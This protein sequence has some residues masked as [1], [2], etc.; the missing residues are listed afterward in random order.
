MG[1]VAML[2]KIDFSHW[3]RMGRSPAALVVLPCALLLSACGG[4]AKGGGDAASTASTTTV[5]TGV[6]ATGAP[7]MGAT[8]RVV[9]VQGISVPLLAADGVATVSSVNTLAGGTYQFKISSSALKFPLMIQAAGFDANGAPMVLHSVVQSPTTGASTSSLV[10]NI[11][12]ATDAVV[13]QVLG[14]D[15]VTVF[16]NAPSRAGDIALLGDAD[17][18]A[19]ASD[20]VKAIIAANLTDAKVANAKTLDLFKDAAFKANKTGLDAALDGVRILMST[21]ATGANQL[22]WSNKFT[23]PTASAPEATL[24]L[25]TAR[26]ELAKKTSGSIAKAISSTTKVTTSPNKLPLL[27]LAAMDT[28][29]DDLNQQIARGT[30]A[31]FTSL[32]AAYTVHNGHTKAELLAKLSG[33][34]KQ[35]YQFG[36]FQ[37]VGCAPVVA[38][39]AAIK[40][41]ECARVLVAAVVTDFQGTPKEIFRDAVKVTAATK[42]TPATWSLIGNGQPTEIGVFPVALARF[43]LDGKWIT[44]TVTDPNPSIGIQVSIRDMDYAATPAKIVNNAIVQVPSGY[45]VPFDYCKTNE[46]CVSSNLATP[47]VA[48][49]ELSDTLLQQPVTGWVGSLEAAKGA[50]Y[51]ISY[52]LAPSVTT[53]NT[54]TAYLPVEVQK[55]PVV[56]NFPTLDDYSG[57]SKNS[58]VAG[59]S[60]SWANW[61][62]SHP[63]LRIFMLRAVVSDRSTT[64]ELARSEATVPLVATSVKI[65]AITASLATT[66]STS[67]QIW[68]GA[69]DA[70]GRRY[71]SRFASAQ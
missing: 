63:Q 1:F 31:S 42:T 56:G 25:S 57:L 24:D 7:L 4:G 9:D 22:L 36:R 10:A 12:P 6:A 53:T 68:L 46:L 15:P 54:V 23:W 61:A 47:T 64:G 2:K 29:T 40:A 19:A 27:E 65:P 51:T 8:V 13:A 11:T 38:D 20:Q 28:L 17:A 50:K 30:D 43:G 49:G 59:P 62:K 44:S 58:I 69:M 34:A 5:V 21:T 35:N 33:Y 18:I 39:D 3:P 52:S 66:T 32:S 55:D 14:V 26:A 60:V 48:F 70:A 16:L 37:V 45:S 67:Y 41:G 71:Y